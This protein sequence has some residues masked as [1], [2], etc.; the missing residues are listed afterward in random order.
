MERDDLVQVAQG[1][2]SISCSP[3]LLQRCPASKGSCLSGI[4]SASPHPLLTCWQLK[5]NTLEVGLSHDSQQETVIDLDCVPYML[6]VLVVV[7][8]RL[9]SDCPLLWGMLMN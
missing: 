9:L 5:E 3:V 7:G 8:L 6:P 1:V 2:T 4:A